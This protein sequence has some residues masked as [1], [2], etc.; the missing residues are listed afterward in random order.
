MNVVVVE[1]SEDKLAGTLHLLSSLPDL[2]LIGATAGAEL[3]ETQIAPSMADL[4][5]LDVSLLREGGHGALRRLRDGARWMRLLLLGEQPPE[6]HRQDC[7]QAGADAYF[8]RSADSREL[9]AL[10]ARWIAPL[11]SNEPAR[12]RALRQLRILDS[13]PEAVFDGIARLASTAAN[14]P[15]AAIGLI[16]G[17]RQWFKAR[18]GLAASEIP[19]SLAFCAWAICGSQSMEVVD[20]LLDARFA[21][22]P[23]VRGTP[24]IRYYLGMPLL[25]ADG[26]AV[27]TL[28]VFDRTPRRLQP[29]QLV[30]LQ[31]LAQSVVLELELRRTPTQSATQSAPA[32][33]ASHSLATLADG[34]RAR[35][36]TLHAE[37][38][39]LR[40]AAAGLDLHDLPW[41]A[42]S[43][44]RPQAM[45]AGLA[46][47]LRVLLAEVEASAGLS[48]AEIAIAAPPTPS[49]RL[50]LIESHSLVRLG[51]RQLL[52]GRWP[53]CELIECA[54]LAQA[55]GLVR[56]GPWQA[57]LLG[58]GLVDAAGLEALVRLHRA[59]PA[60]PILVLGDQVE[61]AYAARALQLG[62]A[63][64]LAKDRAVDELPLAIERVVGGGRYIGQRLAD[65]LADLLA[66]GQAIARPHEILSAQEYRVMLLIA[67]G[68]STGEIATQMHL[69]AKTIGT[70]RARIIK[71]TGLANTA[72]I[73]RYCQASELLLDRDL[74]GQRP[75]RTSAIRAGRNPAP[76]DSH[77]QIDDASWLPA[78]EPE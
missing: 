55:L 56:S 59:A 67:S 18:L 78:S 32:P 76:A 27:G 36:Q 31:T 72:E 5:V 47:R 14:A 37:S 38:Q 46:Q 45:L 30:E 57:A 2:R 77:Y 15:I 49:L 19:R 61:T 3:I 75:T 29:A 63:G 40:W 24:G 66:G 12:L 41:V 23:L 22:N 25:L 71:K 53:G 48:P 13:P 74:V 65:E 73:A 8:E 16:D 42:R 6:Q 58:L 26:A 52:R 39:D 51:A 1:A 10:I 28:C 54:T 35:R 64:C 60:L 11:P 69:S 62:A 33:A 20:T 9:L 50:L 7:L 21:D 4:L 17:E 70:Y 34:D 68:L 43:V 44:P